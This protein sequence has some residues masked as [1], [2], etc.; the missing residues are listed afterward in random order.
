MTSD[1]PWMNKKL[2]KSIANRK[3]LYVSEGGV[4]TEA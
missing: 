2:L 3:R 1:L 4:R